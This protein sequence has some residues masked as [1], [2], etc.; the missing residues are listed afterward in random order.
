MF[1]ARTSR[2][3]LIAAAPLLVSAVAFPAK[4]WAQN[5]KP[6][7][8]FLVVGDWGRDGGEYQRD[9]ATMMSQAAVGS[10][11]I[12]ST[13]DNF[14]TFGVSSVN[15]SKWR[16]SF[17]DVYYRHSSLL[18][19][20]FPVLG[21]HDYGGNVR[22]QIDRRH[23]DERWQMRG[24]WYDVRG[25]EFGRPDVHFFF[26]DTVMWQG[27]ESFP[28]RYF[29]SSIPAGFQQAQKDW[30]ERG[31]RD[32][33]ADIKIVFGHH[34]IYSVGPH[35]GRFALQDLDAVLR[36]GGVTAYVNGHDHCL[37]DISHRGMNYICSG[38]GSEELGKYTGGPSHCVIPGHCGDPDPP[39]KHYYRPL[40]GFATFTIRDNQIETQLVPRLGPSSPPRLLQPPPQVCRPGLASAWREP[41]YA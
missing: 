1:P 9:V 4:V 38:G 34:P 33:P 5:G 14:Y 39:I 41:A 32:S 24:R 15:D 13:G 29:G 22:A 31:L 16:S 26:L 2:R 27:R 25:A 18:K 12:V 36:C 35:G 28:W 21:N 11:F 6:P 17:E 23:V 20:W 37:Y 10:S 30:L 7:L 3:Q 8:H 19:P 40:A